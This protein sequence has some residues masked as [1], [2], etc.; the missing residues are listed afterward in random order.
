MHIL[1]NL[2][3]LIVIIFFIYSLLIMSLRS[4]HPK[5]FQFHPF[6]QL[7]FYNYSN[8]SDRLKLNSLGRS[9]YKFVIVFVTVQ[10]KEKFYCVFL[11]LHLWTVMF[12]TRLSHHYSK[13][14]FLSFSIEPWRSICP[15][16]DRVDH[17]NQ[18]CLKYML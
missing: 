9:I 8:N 6:K 10:F 11:L 5:L 18:M 1:Y 13:I 4:E 15:S 2:A 3:M 16:F 7:C 14:G 12:V 17:P